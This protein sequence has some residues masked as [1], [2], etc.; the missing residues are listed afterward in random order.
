MWAGRG[1]DSPPSPARPV[2]I[3]E[4]RQRPSFSSKNA[5]QTPQDPKQE[6]EHLPP[7][8]FLSFWVPGRDSAVEIHGPQAGCGPHNSGGWNYRV[9]QWKADFGVQGTSRNPLVFCSKESPSKPPTQL[10]S[11][12]FLLGRF[13]SLLLTL[14]GGGFFFPVR[15]NSFPLTSN[16]TPS[17]FVSVFCLYP[18]PPNRCFQL[19]QRGESSG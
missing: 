2:E 12:A 10:T 8:V 5:P 14:C 1:D 16:L 9:P 11:L 4:S 13:C 19:K 15:A 6:E 3:R 7:L 17:L 18:L